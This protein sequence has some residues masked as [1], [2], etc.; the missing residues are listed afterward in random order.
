MYQYQADFP[1][2]ASPKILTIFG[3][4]FL[5]MLDTILLYAFWFAVIICGSK[6]VLAILKIRYLQMKKEQQK[7]RQ[8]AA[9]ARKRKTTNRIP[10]GMKS[11]VVY[12]NGKKT[13]IYYK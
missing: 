10:R 12:M 6:I 4:N 11:Q 1:F 2:L 7:Q 8:R 9:A 3:Q 13:R 5:I